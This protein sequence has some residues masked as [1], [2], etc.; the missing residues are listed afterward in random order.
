M[1]TSLTDLQNSF[2]IFNEQ[3]YVTQ[4]DCGINV[5]T[6]LPIAESAD[7]RF[8][9]LVLTTDYADAADVSANLQV[10]IQETSGL[11][12]ITSVVKAVTLLSGNTYLVRLNFSGSTLVNSLNDGDCF[13]IQ[14][15]FLRDEP[16]A[17][18]SITSITCFK[19]I[20]DKCFTTRISYTNN[21]DTFG[22]YYPSN[23]TFNVIRLPMYAKNPDFDIDQKVYVTSQGVR[24]KQYARLAKKYTFVTDF[25]TEELHQKLVVALNHDAILIQ[26]SN[27]Y[28][29]DVTFENEYSQDFPSIMQGMNVWPSQFV[30]NETPF[31][32]VNNNCQ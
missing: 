32:E 22:F 24:K 12:T 15:N 23:L 10:R 17:N 21:G 25:I 1:A 5:D 4:N 6:C 20:V 7:L 26:T 9:F 3:T 11:T 29:M 18:L 19:F 30:V 16:P 8:Q 27:D 14:L 2:V 31:N 28:I 13:Q